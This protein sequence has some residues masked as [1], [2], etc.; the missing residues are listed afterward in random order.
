MMSVNI[1]FPMD[2]TR[3]AHPNFFIQLL[4]KTGCPLTCQTGTGGG[5]CI[6]LHTLDQT[7]EE[8][9][10]LTLRSEFFTLGKAARYTAQE[11]SLGCRLFWTGPGKFACAGV[12]TLD[13]PSRSVSQ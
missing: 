12:R 3:A 8:H 6:V 10:W 4:W 7:L 2:S 9:V 13:Y 5:R 1:I 11:G